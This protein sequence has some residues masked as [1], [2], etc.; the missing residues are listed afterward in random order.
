[1]NALEQKF[2]WLFLDHSYSI[3][4]LHD[5]PDDEAGQREQTAVNDTVQ[6]AHEILNALNSLG[7]SAH[8]KPITADNFQ[9]V[10][11]GLNGD[12]VFNQVEDSELGFKVLALLE[13]L[14]R[15]VTGVD[16]SGFELSWDKSKIKE[17]LFKAGVPT[18]QFLI[19]K[20]E[21]I[22]SNDLT[23][24]LF[25]KAAEDHGSLS[26]ND[27]SLVNNQQELKNQVDWIRQEIGGEALVE[28]YIDGRELGVTTLGNLD[29]LT[30]LPIKEIVF[31]PQFS[32]KA[33]VVTYDAKW[34]TQS[35][36]YLGTS[37]FDCPAKITQEEEEMVITATKKACHA[38][39]VR[40]Y[41]RFDI[42]LKDGIPYFIDYNANP[43]LGSRDA[44]ALPSAVFGLSY[45]EFL[46]AIVAVAL[47]RYR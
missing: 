37:T 3:D 46:A 13:K 43:A 15:P 32:G 40:D 23:F 2:P 44:S 9:E 25:V 34:E 36:E 21:Y 28:E 41:C 7:H 5:L 14:N 29:D 18:P 11:N 1:M 35:A 27:N 30:I 12:I 6:T 19:T 8:L 10:V 47:K 20:G 39:G 38:L 45:P 42:R 4:I 26:I 31:G 33:K 24:P 17:I 22:Y 16:S